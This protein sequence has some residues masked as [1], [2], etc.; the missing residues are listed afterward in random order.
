MKKIVIL[1]CAESHP[2]SCSYKFAKSSARARQRSEF[3]LLLWKQLIFAL[4][5]KGVNTADNCFPLK[6][7][8]SGS[9]GEKGAI[10][11]T[12][13]VETL[14]F[15]CLLLTWCE[16]WT[17]WI[18]IKHIVSRSGPRNSGLKGL[19]DSWN[20][21]WT[22][23]WVM[24][25]RRSASDRIVHKG[26]RYKSWPTCSVWYAYIGLFSIIFDTSR[27]LKSLNIKLI[28]PDLVNHWLLELDVKT[29]PKMSSNCVT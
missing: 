25:S 1:T 15:C 10:S 23:L 7:G 26:W 27:K 20:T 22:M 18:I 5:S 3:I 19:S 29:M 28:K 6:I 17:G 12:H 21:T 4:I 2:E 16:L 9:F 8:S 13:R 11:S 24:R 14:N